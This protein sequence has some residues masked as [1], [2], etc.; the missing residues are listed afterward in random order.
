MCLDISRER[1]QIS[2]SANSI[3][4]LVYNMRV[5]FLKIEVC[6]W[7][8]ELGVVRQTQLKLC[9]SY[10]NQLQLI[11]QYMD[12]YKKNPKNT[13]QNSFFHTSSPNTPPNVPLTIYKTYTVRR[14]YSFSFW[15]D[16]HCKR[17]SVKLI[18][19]LWHKRASHK[20]VLK[21]MMPLQLYHCWL[22]VLR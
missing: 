6:F 13:Y 9:F 1:K 8:L 11:S 5:E 19:S 20:H 12:L 3:K 4:L 7:M 22:Y 16:V 10:I 14:T 21:I 17:M 2:V 18:T 15:S